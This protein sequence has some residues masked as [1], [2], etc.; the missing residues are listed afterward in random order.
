M[1]S[2]ESVSIVF[3]IF[4]YISDSDIDYLLYIPIESEDKML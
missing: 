1:E 2:S 4:S 3:I